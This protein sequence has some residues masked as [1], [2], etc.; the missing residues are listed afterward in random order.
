MEK[1]KAAVSAVLYTL[2]LALSC[3]GLGVAAGLVVAGFKAT[4]RLLGMA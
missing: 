2:A 3:A 1:L 4:L